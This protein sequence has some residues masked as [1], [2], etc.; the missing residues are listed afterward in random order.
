MLRVNLADPLLQTGRLHEARA[1]LEAVLHGID[2]RAYRGFEGFARVL[3][4]RV[5]HA[6]GDL[7]GARGEL[8]RAV[9]RSKDLGRSDRLAKAHLALPELHRAEGRFD[10]ALQHHEAFHAAEARRFDENSARRLRALQVQVDL[11]QARH[12]AEMARVRH[13]D[14]AQAHRE[15][16]AMHEALVEADREKS[17]LMDRL[18]AQTRTNALTGLANRRLYDAKRLGKDRVRLAA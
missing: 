7:V 15:L 12:D 9:V 3:L 10:L 16:Q 1:A 6:Q 11:S 13:G 5:L 18:E 14:L 17:R 4:G 2:D 8:E